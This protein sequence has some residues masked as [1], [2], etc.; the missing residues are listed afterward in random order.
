MSAEHGSARCVIDLPVR[1]EWKN[2]DLVSTSVRDCFTAVDLDRDEC[3]TIAIVVAELMENAIKYGCWSAEC[4]PGFV[5]VRIDESPRRTIVSVENPV[6]PDSRVLADL[7]AT[8][9][10]IRSHGTAEEAYRERLLE[11]AS[12]KVG[13]LGLVR[14]AFEGNCDIEASLSEDGRIVT[15]TARCHV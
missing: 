14:V 8:I 13:K 9:A 4:E 6:D 5:R 2:I 7:S 15:V 1:T 10:W 11:I 3:H 12:G